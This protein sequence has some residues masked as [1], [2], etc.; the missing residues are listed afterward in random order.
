VGGVGRL[1]GSSWN[2]RGGLSTDSQLHSSDCESVGVSDTL[3][4]YELDAVDVSFDRD[5][6]LGEVAVADDPSELLL[7]DKHPGGGPAL[8]RR[9]P[10]RQRLTLRCV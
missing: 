3:C 2:F 9:S 8:A 4:G 10:S 1:S 7:G 5:H 6:E